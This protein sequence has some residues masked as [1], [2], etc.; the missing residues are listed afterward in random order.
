MQKSKEKNDLVKRN[1]HIVK[2]TSCEDFSI[3]HP[4]RPFACKFER[5]F[6]KCQMALGLTCENRK[7]LPFSALLPSKN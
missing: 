5:A 4:F 6:S 7:L 1:I 2:V 3:F